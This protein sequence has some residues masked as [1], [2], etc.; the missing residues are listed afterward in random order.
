MT[1]VLPPVAFTLSTVCCRPGTPMSASPP[2][3]HNIHINPN[4]RGHVQGGT[5]VLAMSSMAQSMGQP[6][7]VFSQASMSPAFGMPAVGMVSPCKL[8]D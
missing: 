8:N 4:F 2:R 3:P 7:A 6:Q 5:P 1:V